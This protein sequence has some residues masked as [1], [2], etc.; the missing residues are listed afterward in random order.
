M[1]LPDVGRN[2][3]LK[4][5]GALLGLLLAVLGVM[6]VRGVGPWRSLDPLPDG[7]KRP[8]PLS[9]S[10]KPMWDERKLGL[11]RV[12]G[13]ELVGDTAVVAGDAAGGGSRL[14]AVDVRT[15][16]PR[17]TAGSDQ[18]LRGG[19]GAVPDRGFGYLAEKLRG[20]TG[21][22]VV[23]G[24]AND[25]T[26]LVQYVRGDQNR[27]TELGAVAL[28]GK[29]GSVRW[30]HALVRPASG[31]K[32]RDDRDRRIRLLAADP[33]IVL[34]SV[35][36]KDATDLETVALDPSTGRE[37]WRSDAGWAHRITGDVVLG[38]TRGADAP[39]SSS[40]VWGEKRRDTDVFAL[41]LRTGRQLWD[42]HGASENSHLLA[43]AG[44]TAVLQ[45]TERPPGWQYDR[46]RTVLLDAAT[47]RPAQGSP[48][49]EGSA[50]P[51]R[52][53]SG[54]ADDGRT[55]IA[56]S[57][58]YGK[59]VTIR[60]GAGRAPVLTEKRP[61]GEDTM[62]HVDLVRQDRIFVRGSGIGG[63]PERHAV[64]DRAANRLGAAPPG[65]VA[66]V[67]PTAVAFRVQRPG[68]SATSTSSGIV[69]HAA[70]VGA[71]PAEPAA[72]G[73]P[74]LQPP[75][76]DAAP[77]WTAW[78]GPASPQPGDRDTGLSSLIS[79][80]LAGDALVYRGR[81]R[82]GDDRRLVVADAATG[83]VRWSVREGASLGGGAKARLTGALH[84]VNSG[85]E[86]LALVHYEAGGEEGIAALALKD[87]RVRWKQPVAAGG[88]WTLLGGA[89]DRT[90]AVAVSGGD[91][92][93]E[94]VAYATG[95]RRELWRE[96]GVEPVS[97][98]GDLVIAAKENRKGDA[99]DLIAYGASDGKRRWNLAGRY[100]EPE[101]LH[102]GG[103]RTVVVKTAEGGAVLDRA[104][105]RELART[106][107]PLARCDGDTDELIVCQAGADRPVSQAA[108]RAVTI[109][110]T[111]GATRILELLETGT[112]ARYG[113]IGQWFFAVQ[114]GGSGS[115]QDD[116]HLVLDGEG[117]QVAAG[118]PGRPAAIGDGFAV[119][120]QIGERSGAILGETAR[121]SV[122][123][124]RG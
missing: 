100:P 120:M 39:P 10:G 114:P 43:A 28:S 81:E 35:E 25:W 105:G 93:G 98:A 119:L 87:G 74:T 79:L 23:Y 56:C 62:A 37:L 77:L 92:P 27:E 113:A 85:G 101:L 83:K 44:G 40:Y 57:A 68:R 26:V 84:L 88:R 111:G 65:T 29:D 59:I 11:E 53:L 117:R 8:R 55:L 107:T 22:P 97:V 110:T 123:R 54:C 72:P 76:I 20:V 118:L 13:L 91:R 42:L 45:V 89:D 46:T 31:E 47:G 14:A 2:F 30:R 104:T 90:F 73:R 94:T 116:R 61:F 4:W 121:F 16:A 1:G 21:R 24:D 5:G 112:L 64:V 106:N 9:F 109:R 15:G 17:W 70:A 50:S 36:S 69:V 102:D 18:P 60:P 58:L 49:A 122:H 99:L 86:R 78:A 33:R 41:D 96:R 124:V 80:D 108:D 38:E 6:G 34:V 103:G 19:D 82:E 7:E 32:G 12:A 3:A 48:K 51:I 75:R 71:K 63:R 52:D 66:A 67:S 95:S 115:G